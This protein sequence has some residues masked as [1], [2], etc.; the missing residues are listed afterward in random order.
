MVTRVL[1]VDDSGFFRRRI[2]E[3]LEADARIR[4]VGT[5][6]NGKEA[7]AQVASLKPDVVTMDIEMPVMDGITAVRQIMA[8]TPTPVLMFSSLTKAGRKYSTLWSE[9]FTDK[10]FLKKLAKWL[11]TGTVAPETVLTCGGEPLVSVVRWEIHDGDDGPARTR[12]WIFIHGHLFAGACHDPERKPPAL[13]G[14][15]DVSVIAMNPD[16]TLAFEI[17]YR[18]RDAV[19]W[20]YAQQQMNVIRHRM[21]FQEFCALMP[22]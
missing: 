17:P 19:P 8:A 22:A 4:V 7:V 3:I 6:A 5:A 10:P 14:S 11:E 21:A 18:H 20:R 2:V 9:D 12:R 13:S 15:E 1:V 16:R